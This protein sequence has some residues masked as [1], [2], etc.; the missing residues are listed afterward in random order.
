MGIRE[1]DLELTV[2]KFR[3]DFVI[4]GSLGGAEATSGVGVS[5]R[6]EYLFG[7][8]ETAGFPLR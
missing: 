5:G 3:L 1:F 7:T 4:A 8:P 6:T 2:V